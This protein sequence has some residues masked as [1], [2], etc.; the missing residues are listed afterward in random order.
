MNPQEALDAPRFCIVPSHNTY[1]NVEG[2]VVAIEE[3]I[4]METIS[5]LK[6]LGHRIEGPIS[7]YDRAVFGRG[8]I[9]CSKTGGSISSGRERVWWA[10]SDGRADGMAVGY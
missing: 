10:G 5:K 6:A 2:G 7:G 1:G 9:I 8:Q 4:P 3:G